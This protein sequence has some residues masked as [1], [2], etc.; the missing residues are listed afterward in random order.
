MTH[1]T[2]IPHDVVVRHNRRL[3]ISRRDAETQRERE[4]REV[5]SL[6]PPRLG[7]LRVSPAFEAETDPSVSTEDLGG[8][9]LALCVLASL[10]EARLPGVHT[11]PPSLLRRRSFRA[12]PGG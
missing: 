10:R 4:E 1:I 5:L 11:F 9:P 12:S 3:D 2:Q 7:L 8:P 6:S